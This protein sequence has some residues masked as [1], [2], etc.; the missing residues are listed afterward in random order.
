M[1]LR[2]PTL[3][4]LLALAAGALAV[5]PTIPPSSTRRS[6]EVIAEW[7]TVDFA[8]PNRV[9]R[10]AAI[11]TGEFEPENVVVLDVDAYGE[12]KHQRIFVTTPRLKSGVP[13]TLSE[14]SLDESSV[15]PK[16]RP[17]PSWAWNEQGDC[18][19]LISVF[20]TATDQCGRLWVVDSGTVNVFA[21]AERVC[22]PKLVVFDL[23]GGGREGHELVARYTFPASQR[24]PTTLVI[25]VAVDVR[26][27]DPGSCR[28]AYAYVADVTEPAI[29]VYD[30]RRN[31]SWRVLSNLLYPYPLH[32]SF[33]I[34]GAEF[35]LM[36]GVFGMAVGQLVNG[37]RR[38]YFHSLASVRESWVSTRALRNQTEYSVEQGT[39]LAKQFHV[40]DPRRTSQSAAEAID[41][42]G[43]LF[44]SLL[45]ENALACWNT[46]LPYAPKNI[47]IVAKDD[48]TM[49]FGSGLKV[50][51]RHVWMLSSRFQNVMVDRVRP[52][53]TNYRVLVAPIAELVQGTS[54]AVPGADNVVDVDTGLPLFRPQGQTPSGYGGGLSSFGS[55]IAFGSTPPSYGAPPPPSGAHGALHGVSG[56]PGGAYGFS[57]HTPHPRPGGYGYGYGGSTQQPSSYHQQHHGSGS[58]PGP[59]GSGPSAS[60]HSGHSGPSGPG[61]SGPGHSAHSG[62]AATGAGDSIVFRDPVDG[63]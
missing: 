13:A 41:T 35:D 19:N 30:M 23:R 22:P 34:N 56:G 14:L 21:G 54:C 37:D 47:H 27:S 63:F 11:L 31:K 29:L 53:E 59:S 46:R 42:N 45:S 43:V 26:G 10:D 38:L 57:H 62:Y 52:E 28:D 50:V 25:N 7:R 36:D 3:G 58:G 16:L 55:S 8:F 61:Y 2:T 44:F 32:G 39:S 24:E 15:A 40:S 33:K 4:V 60:G 5:L 1:I 20:R 12:G 9:V 17:F 6:M 48:K 51:G 18:D 49:Q